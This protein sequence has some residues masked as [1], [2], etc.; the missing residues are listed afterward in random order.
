MA[1]I[2]WRISSDNSTTQDELNY[3]I[4][5][6]TLTNI[7]LNTSIEETPLTIGIHGP[8]GS[9]KSSLMEMIQENLPDDVVS[10]WFIAWQYDK[11]DTIWTALFQNSINKIQSS[12]GSLNLNN[13]LQV[14]ALNK[15]FL[16][17]LL[18][19]SIRNI[20]KGSL[21]LSEV[22]KH[23]KKYSQVTK[24]IESL[25]DRF[26]KAIE[27]LV[28]PEGKFVIFIDDLDRCLPE[29]AV[30]ILESLKLFL[31]SKHCIFV[32]GV[33]RDVIWK[34]IEARYR[35]DYN[36]KSPIRGKDYIEKIIQ[37]PFNLPQLKIEETSHF[38]EKLYDYHFS[39]KIDQTVLKTITSGI[40]SNPRKIK[41][42]M[43]L[44]S[45]LLNLKSEMELQEI[46]DKLLVKFLVIQSR[47]DDFYKNLI[48][49][50]NL[51]GGENL[52]NKLRSFEK[53][54]EDLNNEES[55]KKAFQSENPLIDI[56]FL[57]PDYFG[58]RNYLKTEPLFED[59][60][61]PYIYL[62]QTT[63]TKGIETQDMLQ[64]LKSA[65]ESEDENDKLNAIREIDI[66]FDK[67]PNPGDL[68]AKLVQDTS[69]T[70]KNEAVK[71]VFENW[72][73]F[74]KYPKLINLISYNKSYFDKI[75]NLQ[76]LIPELIQDD[77]WAIR[78]R[79]VWVV[80]ENYDKLENSQELIKVLSSDTDEHVQRA[81]EWAPAQH[82]IKTV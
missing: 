20:S 58:L 28:G 52:I 77:S 33:D 22:E 65:I 69:A 63:T 43:N 7:I 36:E 62:S 81:L 32:I 2:N 42:F 29:R 76:E 12:M 16:S 24:N 64:D 39:A 56:R 19:L 82:P 75:P 27:G 60:L 18:D 6:N 15:A 9:G 13:H 17:V 80:F 4:Y 59:D 38:I 46:D 53:F 21:S 31:N 49:Y 45:F 34:G 8:W 67:I 70:V 44:Y 23:Y 14:R 78:S 5:A 57:D 40:E 61:R 25:N 11:V 71:T 47:W 3:K 74:K 66:N 73:K 51:T 26:E 54:S 68:L 35:S 79:A 10:L 72:K 55:A 30:E 41:R 37:L 48:N 50:Y 1:D